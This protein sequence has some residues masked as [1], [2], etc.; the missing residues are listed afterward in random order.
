MMQVTAFLALR[1]A[2]VRIAKA[3][4]MTRK[5]LKALWSR[6]G[7]I[8]LALAIVGVI[9]AGPLIQEIWAPVLTKAGW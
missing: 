9:V 7:L 1:F 2:A 4:G 3:L 5:E 6:A 8:I